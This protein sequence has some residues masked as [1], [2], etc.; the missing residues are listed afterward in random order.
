MFP[1]AEGQLHAGMRLFRPPTPG[2]PLLS[3][4][5][6]FADAVATSGWLYVWLN[7]LT[8]G[9]CVC[10]ASGCA[11]GRLGRERLGC[12]H[13]LLWLSIFMF[14]LFEVH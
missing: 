11:R 12:R 8:M 1:S 6:L 2:S 9:G 14:S 3:R 13:P 7:G 4:A 10:C 5:W